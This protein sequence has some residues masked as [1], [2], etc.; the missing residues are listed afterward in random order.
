MY[1]VKEYDGFPCRSELNLLRLL[2]ILIVLFCN[3]G[4]ARA[5]RL[6]ELNFMYI[7]SSEN[8]LRSWKKEYIHTC[9]SQSN[10]LLYMRTSIIAFF[11]IQGTLT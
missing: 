8:S 9:T 6:A 11:N 2:K 4:K 7:L 10:M 5:K 1:R 3:E